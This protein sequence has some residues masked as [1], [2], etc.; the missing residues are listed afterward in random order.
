MK[1]SNYR[2]VPLATEVADRARRAAEA[3]ATDHAVVTATS[4]TEA[5]C[6][7]C[8]RW[9]SPGERVILFPY[10]SIQPGRPYFETGPIFVHADPCERYRRTHEFPADFRRNRV[11]RAYDSDDNM[12]DAEVIEIDNIGQVIERM[13]SNPAAAFLQARSVTRGCYTFRLERKIR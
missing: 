3:G 7:H 13:L 11:L 4:P 9:A 2:I 1:N 10:T 8:L 12:I 5:P 6:R